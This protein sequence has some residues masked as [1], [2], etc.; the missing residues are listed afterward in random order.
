MAARC[1]RY[2]G[3][4]QYCFVEEI[5]TG[6]FGGMVACFPF[7][8]MRLPAGANDE[9]RRV[10]CGRYPGWW[11]LRGIALGYHLPPLRGFGIENENGLFP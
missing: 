4:Y 5:W 1:L 3:Q 9:K 11:L 7:F 2:R 8:V 6:A 10:Y